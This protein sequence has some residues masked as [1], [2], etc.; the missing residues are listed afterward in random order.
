MGPTY[1]PWAIFVGRILQGLW[2][3]GSQAGQMNHLAKVLG[4]KVTQMTVVLN[5]Y[6]CLGFVVGPVFGVIFAGV[7]FSVGPIVFD[8]ITLPGHLCALL[9][10]VCIL[11]FWL[12]FD[13]SCGRPAVPDRRGVS[14]AVAAVADG[15]G[16]TSGRV[17]AQSY[18]EEETKPLLL[19]ALRAPSWLG[20]VVCN[21]VFAVQFFGFALQETITTPIV[22]KFYHWNV[23]QANS[24]FTYAGFLSLLTFIV[25]NVVGECINERILV[26]LSI[27][28]G[29]L[30]YGCLVDV[31]RLSLPLWRFMSGFALVSIAFPISRAV[32]VGLYS[33]VIG[34]RPQGTY[35][36]ILFAVGAVSRILG[37]FYAVESFVAGG[38]LLVFGG[39]A[40]LFTA[41][42][43]VVFACYGSITPYGH[44]C[45]AVRAD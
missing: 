42:L 5:A 22:Q 34:P 32:V 36:G 31:P 41:C 26:V 35:M 9:G 13:D 2:T 4:P 12:L 19:G 15:N 10:V 1:G 38:P 14:T 39:T 16:T 3:G 11:L 28:L 40:L 29:I 6:A 33:K 37:P 27:V 45:D 44:G 8:E 17:D 43:A 21:V 24:L 23:F 18:D 20:I 30:G 7:N 25:L